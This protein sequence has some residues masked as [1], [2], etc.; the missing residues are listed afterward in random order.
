MSDRHD[1]DGSAIQ[2]QAIGVTVSED[3]EGSECEAGGLMNNTIV[4]DGV[5]DGAIPV[6]RFRL[7][8][9]FCCTSA[10]ALLGC[11]LAGV[12]LQKLTVVERLEGHV[13]SLHAEV[14]TLKS[15]IQS[16]SSRTASLETQ[17]KWVVESLQTEVQ[18]PK[19]QIQSSSS[20]LH[21]DEFFNFPTVER[22]S[23]TAHTAAESLPEC[24]DWTGAGFNCAIEFPEHKLVRDWL[25]E[26]ATVLEFGARFGTTSCEIAKK[27]SSNGKVVAVEPDPG[28]WDWLNTNLESHNCNVHILHGIL[29]SRPLVF[30]PGNY[31]SRIGLDDFAPGGVE[32]PNYSFDEVEQALGRKIDSLLIDC[33]G[34]AQYMMDQIEPKLNQINVI[35]IEA[36]MGDNGG[37]CKKN[38]MDYASFI[39]T[40]EAAGLVMVEKK[41]DCDSDWHGAPQGTWCGPWIWHYAFV[42]GG[43]PIR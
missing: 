6:S 10:L 36:D 30:Y 42:R 20:R 22:A 43:T 5:G 24:K 31:A 41:N 3:Q 17:V 25:P 37:D 40:I 29:G 11:V 9:V 35:L 34:C 15:E 28:V 19:S 23:R 18:T 38:C 32:V 4:V 21:G 12:A 14:Q 16:S 13:E 26:D 7:C 2:K 1:N 39:R 8:S 33:E 27:L